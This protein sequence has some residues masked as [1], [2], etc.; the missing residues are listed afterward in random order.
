MPDLIVHRSMGG[1]V[2]SRLTFDMPAK[3]VFQ[4]ALSGPDDWAYVRFWLP[5]KW[6]RYRKRARIM[7]E[8][9]TGQFFNHLADTA[10]HASA[11]QKDLLFAYTAG[12]LCHFYLDSA[13]HPYIL[14]RTASDSVRHTA[15]ERELDRL[16]LKRQ[17]VRSRRPITSVPALRSLPA[18]MRSGLEEAYRLYGWDHVWPELQM[19]LRDARRFYHLTEDPYGLWNRFFFWWRRMQVFSYQCMDDQHTDPENESRQYGPETFQEMVE[20]SV[21]R[22][23]DRI[24]ML[25]AYV[26]GE[27]AWKPM[28]DISYTTGRASQ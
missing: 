20:A 3:D 13:V 18:A 27:G 12:Y 28:E 23:A 4:Y 1:K 17:G 16:E 21:Q 8:Q 19:A 10:K 2:L 6:M 15:L 22:A 7:H 11:E 26:Y 25:H 24:C 14:D 5:W 9:K